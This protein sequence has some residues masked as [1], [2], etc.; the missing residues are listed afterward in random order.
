MPQEAHTSLD[1]ASLLMVVILIVLLIISNVKKLLSGL[2]PSRVA[3][4]P[5]QEVV[6]E[7]GTY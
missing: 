6:G 7:S 5:P 1:F 3:G 2:L 4:R